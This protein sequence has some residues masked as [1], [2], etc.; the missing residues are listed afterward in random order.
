[1]ASRFDSAPL[2]GP[3]DFSDP[4]W[5][6]WFQDVWTA[7]QALGLPAPIVEAVGASPFTYQYTGA[8]QASLAISG[9]T[10]SLIEFSRDG[11]TWYAIGSATNAMPLLSQ[12]DYLRITYVAPPTLTLILR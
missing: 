7:L 4:R 11:T 10:V 3:P 9:G 1:M 5:R 8:G 6:K 12:G 2:Q